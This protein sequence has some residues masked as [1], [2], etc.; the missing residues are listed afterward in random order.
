M[1]P[2]ISNVTSSSTENIAGTTTTVVDSSL[3][4][5]GRS[6]D[7]VIITETVE[8]ISTGTLKPFYATASFITGKVVVTK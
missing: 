3:I 4:M 1:Y 8:S 5:A 7:S 2:C 6:S